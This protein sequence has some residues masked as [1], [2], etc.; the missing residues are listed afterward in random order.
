MPDSP[1]AGVSGSTTDAPEV[2]SSAQT[3]PDVDVTELQLAMQAAREEAANKSA[4][5]DLRRATG[6]IP[7]IQSRLDTIERS[8][9]DSTASR[10]DVARLGARLDALINAIPEGMLSSVALAS[11]RSAPD[12]SSSAVLAKLSALESRLNAPTQPA[13][14]TPEMTPEQMAAVA[15]WDTATESVLSYARKQGV[16]GNGI[17]QDVWQRAAAAHPN[18]PVQAAIDVMKHVDELK[19]K[20]DRQEERKDA[21]QGGSPARAGR[22]GAVTAAQ[23]RTMTAQEIMQIPPAERM[24]ALTRV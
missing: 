21:G 5:A 4:I 18:D 15:Q 13:N 16:D 6:H 3:A 17:G 20:T 9:T 14:T 11:L 8:L 10:Q 19:A 1:E 22:N 7:G 24:A 2:D 12:D 23:L